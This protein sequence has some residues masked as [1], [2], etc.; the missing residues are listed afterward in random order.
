MCQ[1]QPYLELQKYNV[2]ELTQPNRT[3]EPQQRAQRYPWQ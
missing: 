1:I 3:S 2:S